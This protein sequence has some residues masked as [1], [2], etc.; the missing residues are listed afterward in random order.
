VRAALRAGGSALV[1]AL[2]AVVALAPAARSHGQD[3]APTL[4]T[5]L[6]KYGF[7][8][9]LA[10]A[11]APDVDRPLAGW[12]VSILADAFVAA[13]YYKDPAAPQPPP[14][15]HV[16]RFER[17]GARWVHTDIND[18]RGGG[19][20]SVTSGDQYVVVSV[21]INPSTSEGLVLDARSLSRVASVL[22]YD[23]KALDDGSILFFGGMTHFAPIHKQT[24]RLFAMATE[25]EL[26]PGPQPSPVARAYRESFVKAAAA[27]SAAQRQ[28]LA[29]RNAPPDDFDVSVSHL[30]LR[31]DHKRLAFAAS[32]DSDTLHDLPH[33]TMTT[34][35]RCDR[36]APSK[37]TCREQR[38]EDHAKSVGLTVSRRADGGY[39][40]E[41]L[42]AVVAATLKR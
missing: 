13:Y 42:T 29:Q 38:L 31:E 28:A 2:A 8:D 33:P 39:D 30:E 10:A 11:S 17:K 4:R 32:Y 15:L 35:V 6:V 9:A 14:A 27:L 21:H 5:F 18:Q 37:W 36:G 24:L 20:D 25:V 1:L 34:V 7:D 40:D 41:A 19:I 22:G 23:F 12:G 16:S 3:A 26:F